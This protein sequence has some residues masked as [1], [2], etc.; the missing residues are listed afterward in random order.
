[1]ARY[2]VRTNAAADGSGTRPDAGVTMSSSCRANSQWSPAAS[3]PS[4]APSEKRT[5][6]PESGSA[7]R[8]PPMPPPTR[9][10]ASVCS[11][12]ARWSD[13]LIVI[14]AAQPVL[15]DPLFVVWI[16]DSNPDVAW[17]MTVLNAQA[18][19]IS[20]FV[21]HATKRLADRARPYVQTCDGP[22]PDRSCGSDSDYE[23][24]FSGHASTAATSAGLNCAHHTNLPLYGGG[25]ADTAACV[26]GIGIATRFF[27]VGAICPLAEAG[28]GA[29]C[30][31][32]LPNP[33]LRQR[34]LAL[35]REGIAAPA[36]AAMVMAMDEARDH[37]QLH[38]VDREGQNSFVF[39]RTNA[40]GVYDVR[41]GNGR[42]ASQRFAVNLF[43]SRES[44]LRPARTIEL[45]YES[46]V[47]RAALEPS[48]REFWKWLLGAG[49]V[50]LVFEWYVY[51]RRVYL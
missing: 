42:D 46:V 19:A 33:A 43:D 14:G 36:A 37:R 1:M 25:F 4:V 29:V 32:A 30:S 48:R 44:D 50:V 15:I 28:Q 27:A 12:A 3:T 31:Q 24:F 26:F 34:A 5:N 11:T 35:L 39:S 18:H 8:V 17:Q 7:R 16:G 45:G 23:A 22:E 38:L 40:L 2:Q 9:S 49:L 10:D 51:N 13:A 20:N 41:E 6:L 47:G 21:T